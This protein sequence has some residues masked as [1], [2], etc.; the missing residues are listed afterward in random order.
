MKWKTYHT[1]N[2]T[3][4]FLFK[5]VPI[6]RLKDFVNSGNIWF[7]RADKFGDK[8]ECIIIPDLQNPPINYT[9][10]LNR[11]KKT[12]ISCWHL[13]NRESVAMWDTYSSRK[14]D[15]KNIAIRFR[16]EDLIKAFT[17][18]LDL[19]EAV[20]SQNELIHG[21]IQ[22]KDLI[23]SNTNKL[24]KSTVK[25]AAFR[26][27]KAFSYELEYRFTIKSKKLFLLDG[28][29][30]LLGK[31]KDLKFDILI[32]PLLKKAEFRK[33]E[34]EISNMGYSDRIQNSVL[35]EWFMPDR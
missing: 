9:K 13:A 4:E 26:K 24:N 8:M 20:V 1:V 22:Y 19:N 27:E 3:E 2:L 10:I 12:L 33:L 14:K 11:K 16:R 18:S 15:R 28:Q 30:Y 25:Y 32:N 35:K 5:F 34:T 31:T 23:D 6:Y 21:K 7:S 29:G 17:E